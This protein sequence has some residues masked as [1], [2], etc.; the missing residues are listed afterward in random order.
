M[1]GEN[2]DYLLCPFLTKAAWQYI[3]FESLKKPIPKREKTIL[4]CSASQENC[5]QKLQMILYALRLRL[6]FFTS[7]LVSWLFRLTFQLKLATLTVVSK[8]SILSTGPPIQDDANLDEPELTVQNV[9]Y[10]S[11]YPLLC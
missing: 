11:L 6:C 7:S 10:S 4:G 1:K 8:I 5:W 2:V 9:R 3:V